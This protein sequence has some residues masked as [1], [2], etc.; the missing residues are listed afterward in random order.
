V[1]SDV[2]VGT[3]D[4]VLPIDTPREAF[5][6]FL[7]YSKSALTEQT[8]PDHF[9]F[10]DAHYEAVDVSFI[11]DDLDANDL[12]GHLVW[13]SP[14]ISQVE[15]YV[16]FLAENEDGGNRALV[17]NV[18]VG[19]DTILLPADTAL[20]SHSH[21][22]IYARSSLGEQTT[23]S[24]VVIVDSISS[25][26][27][28]ALLDEDLDVGHFG[29]Q[30]SWTAPSDVARVVAYDF[31]LAVSVSG[32]GGTQIGGDVPVGTNVGTLPTDTSLG[33]YTSLVV[34]TKSTL[35]EQTTPVAFTSFVDA[36]ASVSNI[37]FQ[38]YD[39][40]VLDFGGSLEWSAP[41]DTSQVTAY[42]IYL[43]EDSNGAKR[44]YFGN[45]TAS[46]GMPPDLQLTVPSDT[47]F[48]SFTHFLV[49]TASALVE[50]TTPTNEAIDNHAA[51][52]SDI[53]FLDEDLDSAEL[54]GPI[55]W[56][57][58]A[59]A[60]RVIAYDVFFANDVAGL[61]RSRVGSSTVVG[62][63][64]IVANADIPIASFTHLLIY[65]Q[66][67][68]AEQTTPVAFALVDL[69]ATVTNMAFI[70][71]D[72]DLAQVGGVLTWSE[73]D[74]AS[75]VVAYDVYMAEGASAPNRS[76]VG[77]L[78]IGNN[79]IV[80]PAD[81]PLALYSHL[82]VY[83]RSLF[84]EQSTPA[85]FA[86]VDLK[87]TVT[88][89]TLP[90]ND[91]DPHEIGGVLSWNAPADTQR[92]EGYVIYFAQDGV[93]GS[94]HQIVEV[95]LGTEKTD[96]R[97][98]FQSHSHVVVYTKSTFAEQTT[99]AALWIVDQKTILANLTFVD[100][101]LDFDQIG[102]N[103]VWDAPEDV[104]LATD[105]MV[106]LAKDSRGA[107]RSF[108]GN[109]TFGQTQFVVSPE[110]ELGSFTHYVVYM[111][112][113]LLEQTTPGAVEIY[114][115]I[116]SVSQ[117]IFVG[118]DL[119]NTDLGGVVRWVP[120]PITER[121]QFY[122]VYLA[123][124]AAGAERSQIQSPEPVGF[125][126][127]QVTANTQLASFTHFAVY[128]QSSLTE[129]TTPA[130]ALFADTASRAF[131]MTFVDY[132]LDHGQVGGPL[133]WSPP[134]DMTHV[135]QYFVYFAEN[136]AGANRS[137]IQNVS[138]GTN[139]IL[140]SA[141][142]HREAFTHFVVYARSSLEEQTTPAALLFMDDFASVSGINFV[143]MDLD[144]NEIGGRLIWKDPPRTGKVI[145]Y[146]CYFAASA[147]GADRIHVGS[148]IALGTN[149]VIFPP[150]TS[151]LGRI[152]L[153]IYTKSYLAEQTTPVAV[154]PDGFDTFAPVQNVEFPDVDLDPTQ[155]GGELSWSPPADA[156]QITYYHVYWAEPNVTATQYLG[157]TSAGVFNI[158]VPMEFDLQRFTQFILFTE[159]SLAVQ[160]TYVAHT[161]VDVNGGVLGLSFVDKDFDLEDLGGRI[162]WSAPPAPHITPILSYTVFL[163]TNALGAGRTLVSSLSVGSN[164]A[165]LPAETPRSSWTHVVV[166]SRSHMAEQSTPV[167]VAIVDTNSPVSNVTFDDFDLDYTELG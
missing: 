71:D 159:S 127:K 90:D 12:G 104:C 57:E 108:S 116:A 69:F 115:M 151:T 35:A 28:I 2:P 45:T 26:S 13:K 123:Q 124:S 5:R 91:C 27:G 3:N 139:E 99:P 42:H 62:T 10:S 135:V 65:A 25:V 43:A 11:D 63:N 60:S 56:K 46:A 107:N 167:A 119:D 88:G 113:T 126:E 97:S 59:R 34:Y 67:S 93:G 149:T 112:S 40:D 110:T 24:A 48:M 114:D 49:Y 101:D 161:I 32:V 121:V 100:L 4:I 166:Y 7:V 38:D 154:D 80:L 22:V 162:A 33:A 163:A 75:R 118:K 31:Y 47:R 86:L 87:A 85:S 147:A 73:P 128:T 125:K 72:L 76:L 30:V 18:T 1:G 15:E 53:Y 134:E 141:D 133:A 117:I 51:S 14:D 21:L 41:A 160:N 109:V 50:Q 8:T 44:S 17:G 153:L 103:I 137:F 96:V 16:V 105:Y 92:V 70:D 94:R 68:L 55:N 64:Q 130:A 36:V 148:S 89:I 132:D 144:L 66:S 102:G 39:L 145:S 150:E 61:D 79:T 111:L 98:Q 81:T 78:V 143:D 131:N 165:A 20:M 122:R 158:T 29:G 52:V 9:R 6:Y 19:T 95:P 156:S 37:T 136:A 129:Q 120:P 106:Y 82:V 155:V 23:P 157:N 146:E 77:E 74:D 58:P 84:V 164:E 152:Y 140:V 83:T 54:G 142:S 138:E